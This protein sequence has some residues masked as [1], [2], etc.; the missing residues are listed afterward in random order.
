MIQTGFN[1]GRSGLQLI[2]QQITAID[3]LAARKG[4]IS[5]VVMRITS[6]TGLYRHPDILDR[7]DVR[8]S[9]ID[10]QKKHNWK[11]TWGIGS[12][13][14]DI[15]LA[16]LQAYL[17]E[18]LQIEAFYLGNEQYWWKEYNVTPQQYVAW[19]DGAIEAFKHFNKAFLINIAPAKT[20]A[21]N[22]WNSVIY[23]YVKT[24]PD[25]VII[26]PDIHVYTTEFNFPWFV[27]AQMRQHFPNGKVWVSEYGAKNEEG[28][29]SVS[30]ELELWIASEIKKRLVPGDVMQSHMLANN[31]TDTGA[32]Q[33]WVNFTNW[34]PKGNAMFE[35]LY[36]AT[37]AVEPEPIE[38]ELVE[39]G[40][41][42][43]IE[44]EP[45]PIKVVLEELIMIFS[46]M[47]RFEQ[48]LIFSDGSIHIHRGQYWKGQRP[49][50]NN[51][52]GKTKEELGI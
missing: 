11:T 8:K 28:G 49:F 10:S 21:H 44:P 2:K 31:M 48:K 36:P 37:I 4:D 41:P 47:L 51:D 19:C 29:E 1:F 43:I 34:T 23:E 40:P 9:Y 46:N 12:R 5:D 42:I 20:P 6:G 38:S 3:M 24:T 30:I 13:A 22:N 16:S 39:S 17:N 45:E 35:L 27:F 26:H 14:L 25:D 50:S 33:A 52:K 15:E 32:D 7:A 18:G